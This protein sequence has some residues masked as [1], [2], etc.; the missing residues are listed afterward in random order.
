[1]REPKK[2]LGNTIKRCRKRDIIIPAYEEMAHPEKIP[3]GI[4]YLLKK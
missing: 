3:K 1:M 4:A 2:V